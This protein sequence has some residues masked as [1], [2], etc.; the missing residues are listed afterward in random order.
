MATA[1][2]RGSLLHKRY[3]IID[4]LG[5]GGM[6]SVY[7]AIDENL[8]V[9]VA[10]KENLFTTD[11]YARQFRLEAVILANLRHANLPRVTDHFVIGEQGQYLIMDYIEGEDLRQRMER[12]GT[13]S[14]E[15]A[16]LIGAAMCEALQYLHTRKPSIIHRDVKP[17]NVRITPDGHI[18]LVDFGL[19]K[20]VKGSQATT[21]GARAMTPGYSPPEQYGTA[22]TDPRTDI[23]SLGATLYAAVTGVIP[24]DGLARAMDN[25]DLTPV[26]KRN[27]R[28]SRK[29]AAAIEKAMAVRPENRFQ[30]AEEF[31]LA[32]LTSNIKTQKV[33]GAPVVDPAPT[34]AGEA[35]SQLEREIA[36]ADKN[37]PPIASRPRR[38]RSTGRRTFLFFF[39][40]TI[41]LGVLA[42]IVLGR[43][44]SQS[45]L[46][47]FIAPTQKSQPTDT[48]Q[49]SQTVLLADQPSETPSRTATITQTASLT[50]TPSISPTPTETP[51]PTATSL[52]G[53]YSQIAFAS[54]RAGVPQIFLMNADGGEPRQ[55]TNMPDGACQP[56]WSPDGSRLVFISPCMR[57]QDQYPGAKL[58]LVNA[59][60]GD[61]TELPASDEGDFDPAWSPDGSRI[62]FTSLLDGSMQIYVLNLDD[63]SVIKLTETTS[64]T[65]YPDWSRQPA[66]S[67]TGTQLLYTGHSRLTNAL[68]IWMMS[69][70]GRGQA[71]FVRR[72]AVLWNDQPAWSPDGKVVLF[73]E[74]SGDQALGWLM[75]IDAEDHQSVEAVR[76]RSGILGNHGAFSPDGLWVVY[77]NLDVHAPNRIDYDL[78]R[79]NASS[80]PERLTN[81][82]A[83]DF[84]P[85]WRPIGNP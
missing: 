19:A 12:Q 75:T 64:D 84:D 44:V 7:R 16:I 60:G 73:G 37:H 62:A 25:V 82:P 41:L 10:V 34:P 11:E 52:G 47:L 71:I 14:E 13:V 30:S 79:M 39:L 65:R 69:D 59:E 81:N 35:A 38:K 9:A 4:I 5:Q 33:E 49:P 51:P 3:R 15:D 31:R 43:P 6:G 74:A 40:M 20:L 61:L 23:Y 57:R 2:E 18:F 63:N 78:Y 42:V 76:L 80:D 66:W 54:D 29:L 50:L 85:D 46:N 53:G 72:G 56:D 22:R 1:L 32:L 36:E 45:L 83:Q 21:T 48:I 68:Q 58:Y 27:P 24:E 26:R 55:I 17:G 77:E 8:G 70:A 28:I 67:P